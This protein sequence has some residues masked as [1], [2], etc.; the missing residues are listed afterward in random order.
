MLSRNA[1]LL[2]LMLSFFAIESATAQLFKGGQFQKNEAYIGEPFGVAKITIPI[3]END[4]DL[5]RTN[6]LI[7]S[8]ANGRVHYPV[9]SSSALKKVIDIVAGQSDTP[10]PK[11]MAVYFLFTGRDPFTVKVYTSSA[12][13]VRVDPGIGRPLQKNLLNRTWWREF[14]AVARS[15]NS[16]GDYP[17]I[18]ET[19]LTAMLGERLG[20]PKPLIERTTEIL[21]VKDQVQEVTDFFLGAELKHLKLIR[22]SMV[23]QNSAAGRPTLPLPPDVF[24]A[25]AT[26][27]VEQVGGPEIEEIASHV[28]EECFYVRFGEWQNQ[29]WLQRL[30][31]EYGGDIGRMAILRGIEPNSASRMEE[32]LCLEQDPLAETFGQTVIADFAVIGRDLNITE[33]AALGVLFQQRNGLLK[34]QLG[35]GREKILNREK[36]NGAME[37]IVEIAG[38]KVSLISTVDNRLRSYYAVHDKFHLITNCKAMVERFFECG[39][40]KGSL[41]NSVEFMKTRESY[42]IEN[43]DTVFVF[44]PTNFFRGMLSSKYQIENARRQQALVDIELLQLAFAAAKGEGLENPTVEDLVTAK[45]LPANF[46][47]RVDMSGPIAANSQVLDSLRGAR[48]YFTPIPDVDIRGITEAEAIDLEKQNDTIK[49]E[50]VTMVP[51]VATIKREKLE[52]RGMERL[53]FSANVTS[54][55]GKQLAMFTDSLGATT[56]YK[57]GTSPNDI[58]NFHVSLK[59]G[60]LL[61]NVPQHQVFLAIQNE[62]TPVVTVKPSG[63]F[64][65]LQMLKGFPGYIGAWP[66]PGFLDTFTPQLARTDDNGFS[67]SRLLDLHRIQYGEYSILAFDKNRLAALRPNLGAIKTEATGQVHGYIGDLSSSQLVPLINTLFYQRAMQ[68]SLGNIKLL[69]AMTQQLKAD[70]LGAKQRVESLLDGKLICSLEG[71]YKTVQH[72]NGRVYWTS[73]NLPPASI[74]QLPDGYSANLLTWFRGA[75]FALLK[76]E[77]QIMVSGYV[78]MK[79]KKSERPKRDIAKRNSGKKDK[80]ASVAKKGTGSIIPGFNLFGIGGKTEKKS[81]DDKKNS[82]DEKQKEKRGQPPIRKD[83]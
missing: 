68:A 72:P 34:S 38:N 23:G 32:Q 52:E 17:P 36:A 18:I 42:P 8:E 81:E 47:Q 10:L 9:F 14:N 44:M 70:P 1:L 79:H 48:G 39:E 57:H 65:W 78:D 4:R 25:V 45:F 15:R 54:L 3:S 50:W 26:T 22:D 62:Q 43:E 30:G 61:K 27:T 51:L 13:T 12:Y 6:G 55:L 20:L 80:D 16:Q 19:Y 75:E 24:P 71:E 64:G 5:L 77:G 7:I 82:G 2:I 58:I 29:V 56:Q 60:L 63:F 37:E 33:G 66:K 31:R 74:N 83:D 69:N 11:T 59:E 46:S 28:P 53:L 76:F 67:Y 41:A 73:E 49:N 40:G 35:T 21:L